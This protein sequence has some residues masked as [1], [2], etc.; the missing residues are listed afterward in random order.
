MKLAPWRRAAFLAA[1]LVA[2]ILGAIS[3]YDSAVSGVDL[4]VGVF[5]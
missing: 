4:A 3:A 2:A 5:R 1:A